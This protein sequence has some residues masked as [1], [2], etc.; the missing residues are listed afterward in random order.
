MLPVVLLSN[1]A[2]HRRALVA[3]LRG[4]GFAPCAGGPRPGEPGGPPPVPEGGVVVLD[5]GEEPGPALDWCRAARMAWPA[6]LL[7]AV[8]RTADRALEVTALE[9]GADVVVPGPPDARRLAAQLRA[10]RRPTLVEAPVPDLDLDAA[11]RSAIIDGLS[12]SLTDAEF[13]LLAALHRHRGQLLSRDDLSQA[14][15]GRP[16]PA[17]DRSLDLRVMR[18][19]RKLGDDPQAPRF[20]RAVRGE[21]YLLLP[22]G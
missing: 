18:L 7:C 10:L 19:R 3:A 9:Q 5:L 6:L 21:G 1:D 11:R 8:A 12:V 22:A 20:I 16:C 14:L 13:E 4:S 15:R 2:E 17:G